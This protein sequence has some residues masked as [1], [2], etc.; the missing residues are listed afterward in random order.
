MKNILRTL[1]V[2]AAFGLGVASASNPVQPM[3]SPGGPG[4]NCCWKPGFWST[5]PSCG[6]PIPLTP[7]NL[8]THCACAPIQLWC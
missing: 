5:I 1:L 4:H 7:Q 3:G 8:A 2:M 6:P